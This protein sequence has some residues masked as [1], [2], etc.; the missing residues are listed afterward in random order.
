[1]HSHTIIISIFGRFVESIFT[2][3]GSKI[4][5]FITL[6]SKIL[7][8]EIVE[9]VSMRVIADKTREEEITL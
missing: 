4:C 3:P 1:M 7:L 6:S 5:H 2:K 9:I 8:Q